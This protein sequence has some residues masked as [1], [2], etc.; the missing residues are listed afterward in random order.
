MNEL[1]KAAKYNAVEDEDSDVKKEEKAPRVAIL[2][3][4]RPGEER[5]MYQ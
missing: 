4:V 3:L 1:D 5:T 2:Q